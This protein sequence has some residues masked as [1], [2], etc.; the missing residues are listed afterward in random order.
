MKQTTVRRMRIF[1]IESP[2]AMDVLR[3]RTESQTLLAVCRLLGHDFAS[4]IVHSSAEFSTAVKHVTTIDDQE[5]PEKHRH[6]PLC[7]HLAAHGNDDGLFFGPDFA[8]WEDLANHL[9]GFSLAMRHYSGPLI[10]IISACGAEHQAVTE[11]FA[12]FAAKPPHFRPAAYVLTTESND[13][14]EVYWRDSVVAWSIFYH[15]IGDAVLS[16]RRSVKTILDKI[17]LVG[18]GSLKYFRW[19]EARRKYMPFSSTMAEH[20]RTA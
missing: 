11:W 14:G 18:A 7:L 19:D 8:S 17:R 9:R 13:A 2:S 10:L 1:A 6:R 3:N 4:T 12:R 5:I 20:S 16:K 15:Q